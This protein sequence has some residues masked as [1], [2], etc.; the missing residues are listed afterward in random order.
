[1]PKI[2]DHLNPF[3]DKKKV[4]A[5]PG[6]VPE[7]SAEELEKQFEGKPWQERRAFLER[8]VTPRDKYGRRRVFSEAHHTKMNRAE[9]RAAAKARGVRMAPGFNKPLVRGD[10]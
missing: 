6:A 3:A 1:M 5:L 8:T 9:R 4:N 10:A 2:L 7:L